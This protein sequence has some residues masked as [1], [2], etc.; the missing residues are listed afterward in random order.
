[1]AKLKQTKKQNEN[2]KKKCQASAKTGVASGG[3]EGLVT[4]VLRAIP[5]VES[6][7]WVHVNS[8]RG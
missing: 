6:L 2:K 5:E 8:R 4:P 3:H 7:I 1:M